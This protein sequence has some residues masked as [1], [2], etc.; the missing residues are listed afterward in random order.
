MHMIRLIMEMESRWTPQKAMY[1]RT[2][3]SMEMMEKATQSEHTGLGMKTTETPI[4]TTAAMTTH[5]TVFGRTSRNWKNKTTSLLFM[6]NGIIFLLIFYTFLIYNVNFY[7][8]SESPNATVV[9]VSYVKRK[10]SGFL[11]L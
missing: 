1:P 5:C 3:S 11:L 2:P 9:V 4:M 7:L 6:F 10:K 8:F